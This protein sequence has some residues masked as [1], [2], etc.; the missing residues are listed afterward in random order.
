MGVSLREAI[1]H[2]SVHDTVRLLEASVNKSQ[3]NFIGDVFSL[4]ESLLDT[5]FN[6]GV[7]FLLVTH[8]LFRGDS[9]K[10]E[11]LSDDLAL[12]STSRAGRSDK[13][14]LWGSTGSSIAESNS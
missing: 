7:G 13:H 3:D 12:R 8:Q 5:D 6:S 9:D 2:P 14:D 1:K 10:S 11:S 4:L